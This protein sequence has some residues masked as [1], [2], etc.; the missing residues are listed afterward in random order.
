VSHQI[1]DHDDQLAYDAADPSD[2]YGATIM[3]GDGFFLVD[4]VP[5]VIRVNEGETY[6]LAGDQDCIRSSGV[7]GERMGEARKMGFILFA[8]DNTSVKAGLNAW[9]YPQEPDL[10]G[11]LLGLHGGSLLGIKRF[12]LTRRCPWQMSGQKEGYRQRGRCKRPSD[13]CKGCR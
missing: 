1:A 3:L 4:L 10:D 9:Y 6:Q 2:S 13:T 11:H 5:T 12:I 8:E 7:L